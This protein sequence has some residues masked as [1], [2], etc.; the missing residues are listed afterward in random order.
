MLPGRPPG[1]YRDGIGVAPKRDGAALWKA[2]QRITKKDW[3]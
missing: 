2:T 1:R 3:G